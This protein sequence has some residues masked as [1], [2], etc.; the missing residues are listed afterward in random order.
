VT[1]FAELWSRY[2]WEA[3]AGCPGRFVL[4]GAEVGGPEALV[5]PDVPIARFVVA[6]ARHPVLVAAIGGGGVIS[7]ARDDGRYVHTLNTD[8]GFQRKLAQLGVGSAIP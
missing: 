8:E 3:I 6:T 5:G 4:R 2:R 1:T 7:Y